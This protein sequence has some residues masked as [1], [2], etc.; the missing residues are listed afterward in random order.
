[1]SKFTEEKRAKALLVQNKIT[2]EDKDKYH[3]YHDIY[4]ALQDSCNCRIPENKILPGWEDLLRYLHRKM[5]DHEVHGR[6]HERLIKLV[7]NLIAVDTIP[8]ES[9]LFRIFNDPKDYAE[10][11]CGRHLCG[12]ETLESLQFTPSRNKKRSHMGETEN[13]E[14]DTNLKKNN[15]ENL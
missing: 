3:V 15:V 6:V 5:L 12:A 14:K 7:E 1:M 10:A 2:E 11:L 4:H 9:G 13:K 8:A